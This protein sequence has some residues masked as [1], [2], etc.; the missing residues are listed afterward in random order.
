MTFVFYNIIGPVTVEAMK[1]DMHCPLSTLLKASTE[2]S[3][4]WGASR[5]VVCTGMCC[6]F[7]CLL[8]L[9]LASQCCGC[10]GGRCNVSSRNYLNKICCKLMNIRHML[11]A[12]VLK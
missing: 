12:M 9:R 11:R 1:R 5:L 2:V 3:P 10:L 4:I 6:K 7:V 8:A